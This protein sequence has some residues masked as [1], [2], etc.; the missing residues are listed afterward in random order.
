MVSQ[1]SHLS[2]VLGSVFLSIS[3]SKVNEMEMRTDTTCSLTKTRKFTFHVSRTMSNKYASVFL[4]YT[5]ILVKVK[6]CLDYVFFFKI[7]NDAIQES[8]KER[9]QKL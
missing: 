3:D 4:G 8:L 6:L 5:Y 7:I 2:C 9:I 1:M